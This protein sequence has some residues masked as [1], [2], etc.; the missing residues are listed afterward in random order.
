[1]RLFS[2]GSHV[3]LMAP[4]QTRP[5]HDTSRVLLNRLDDRVEDDLRQ[6]VDEVRRLATGRNPETGEPF[7][8][9][10]AAIL[11][12]FLRRNIRSPTRR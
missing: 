2:S 8:G 10:V 1:M 7:A 3:A 11:D 9:D 6:E 4:G 12:T 5:G